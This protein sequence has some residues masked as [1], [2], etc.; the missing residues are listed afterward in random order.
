MFAFMWC[1]AVLCGA[2]LVVGKRRF[3]E[4]VCW[5][6]VI[7]CVVGGS[8]KPDGDSIFS[9]KTPGKATA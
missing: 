4:L 1:D 9:K 5:F 8:W 6:L 3:G 2:A 7:V